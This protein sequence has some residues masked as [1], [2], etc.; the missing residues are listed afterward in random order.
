MRPAVLPIVSARDAECNGLMVYAFGY[1]KP[2]M[3]LRRDENLARM[4]A[5]CRLMELESNE[6]AGSQARLEAENY[7]VG[8]NNGRF[9]VHA[10][11]RPS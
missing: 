5:Q 3:R 2:F 4:R 8:G 11:S 1:P 10:R 7:P 6:R 9:E